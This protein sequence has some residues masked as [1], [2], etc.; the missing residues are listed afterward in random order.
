[1]SQILQRCHGNI[2]L[3]RKRQN[4]SLTL[5]VFRNQCHSDLFCLLGRGNLYFLSIQYNL[6]SF[7]L[8]RTIQCTD[9][10]RTAGSYQSNQTQDLAFM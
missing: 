4:Q 7:Y 9:N 10:L 6:M 5:T 1:M 3:H 8:I 2:T